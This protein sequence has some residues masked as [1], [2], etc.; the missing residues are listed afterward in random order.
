MRDFDEVTQYGEKGDVLVVTYGNG[1]PTALS[2]Q[3]SASYAVTVLDVPYLSGVGNSLR[4]AVQQF[5][6]VVFADVCKFGQ[7]PQASMVAQLQNDGL[8]PP[9]WCSIGA[10]PTYNPL[11]QMLTF[12]S[13]EDIKNAIEKVMKL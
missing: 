4:D 8:L 2:V 1:V 6:R 9:K 5:D 10:C 11:G 13:A 12:L 3:E 7:H